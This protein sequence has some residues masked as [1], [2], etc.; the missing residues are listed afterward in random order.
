MIK[1]VRQNKMSMT[2]AEQL[3]QPGSSNFPSIPTCLLYKEDMFRWILL[4][5]LMVLLNFSPCR[6]HG[7]KR[8]VFLVDEYD[9]A[10]TQEG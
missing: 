8:V 10:V 7:D 5:A 6:R 9:A 1:V 2:S 3:L 4:D